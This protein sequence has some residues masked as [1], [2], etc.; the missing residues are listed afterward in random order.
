[1]AEHWELTVSQLTDWGA[2][3]DEAAQIL[4]AIEKYLPEGPEITWYELTTKGVL[5]PDLP[6]A[7]HQQLFQR[8]YG[9][10]E[11]Y[12]DGPMAW[13]PEEYHVEQANVTRLQRLLGL[14]NYDDF[15]TWSVTNRSGFWDLMV[16]ELGIQL[17]QPYTQPVAVADTLETPSWLPGASL[18]IAEAC[19]THD[20]QS[21]AIVYGREDGSMGSVTLDELNR[22]SNR[23][24]NGLVQRGF[25]RGDTAAIDMPMTAEAVAI[26]LGIV[27]AGGAVVSIADSLAPAEVDKRL[28]IAASHWLFTQDILLRGDKELPLYEKLSEVLP[29]ITVV[30]PAREHLSV[31]I[32]ND[33]ME[34][35]DFLTDEDEFTPVA[36]HPD[37]VCNILFSS[38]TTGDPKAIPWTHTTPIKCAADGYIHHDIHAGEVVAWPT[39]IGWMMGPWLIFASLINK[40]TI[41]LY[42]GAPAGNSFGAFVSNAK[43]NM[44]G[45]V[46]SMVKRWIETDCMRG[47]DWSHIRCYSSTGESS[48]P[49]DYLWL[50]ARAG[51]KPVIEYCGGTEIGGGYFT[52]AM[53]QPASPSTFSTCA[54]G[55]DVVILNEGGQPDSKGELYLVPPSIGLSTRLLNKNHHDNYYAGTPLPEMGWDSASGIALEAQYRQWR[56]PPVLRRHG[57]EVEILPTG[58]FRAHGRADDTMNLGGIKTSSVEIERLLDV[59]PGV[60][61]TAAIAVPS[62]GGGPSLLVIYVVAREG[63][64]PDIPAWKQAFQQAIRQQLNP[65]F[66]IHAIIHTDLLPRTASNKVMRR[67]LRDDYL[68]TISA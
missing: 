22:L 33:D 40:A 67:V 49:Q 6:A 4:T 56:Q 5:H 55:L 11:S 68:K 7:V 41:A 35:H 30:L 48:N 3:P 38:G 17:R 51:Y 43:V 61:E 39:N 60:K 26:Y 14:K 15:F 46:P 34:W 54:C 12:G 47:L 58:Y 13:W 9:Q 65:L 63:V 66:H 31:A 20:K 19:F 42:Y 37:E 16:R 57:D 24:A 44:L 64:S 36:M 10:D 27:K 23:V 59:L 45:V 28:R 2:T 1:M 25:Q 18:N 53:V 52:G 62:P 29:A 50:M 21:T 8:I 32:R